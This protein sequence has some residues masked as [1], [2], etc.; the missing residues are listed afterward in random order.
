MR[1][2]PVREVEAAAKALREYD[3]KGRIT[4]PWEDLPRYAAAKWRVRAVI[5]LRAAYES[6]E[7]VP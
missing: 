5:A 6:R 2:L 1:A 4:R 7:D 3:M